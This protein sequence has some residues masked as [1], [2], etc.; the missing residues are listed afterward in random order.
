M[1]TPKLD[2]DK[3][4]DD[5]FKSSVNRIAPLLHSTYSKGDKN[6]SMGVAEGQ[7]KAHAE[8]LALLHGEL[9]GTV[10]KTS[11]AKMAENTMR[12]AID[13]AKASGTQLTE[14]G[15]RKAFYGNAVIEGRVGSNKDLYMTKDPKNPLPS[16]EYQVVLGNFL[17]NQKKTRGL[18]AGEASNAL[19]K[20]WESL[21]KNQKK[22]YTD[23]SKGAPGS[24]PMLFW[25]YST[26]G[27]SK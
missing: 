19:E 11:F 14:E 16:A 1:I 15:I 18:N 6:Y 10:D 4:R 22:K 8:A 17:D 7:A 20:A 25:L 3:N 5:I 12:S 24:T 27:K 13:T 2:Y 23:M 26:G 9:G 21:D